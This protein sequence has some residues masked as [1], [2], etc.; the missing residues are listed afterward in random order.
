MSYAWFLV[1]ATVSSY[2]VQRAS[3]GEN[4]FV[5]AGSMHN[6]GSCYCKLESC[7][8]CMHCGRIVQPYV[9]V[10]ANT[11]KQS[12]AYPILAS[13]KDAVHQLQPLPQ[14]RHPC[15]QPICQTLSTTIHCLF[16]S[17]FQ[18]HVSVHICSWSITTPVSI[19]LLFP[20]YLEFI[21]DMYGWPGI[22]LLRSVIPQ[23]VKTADSRLTSVGT[24]WHEE[25]PKNL[26]SSWKNP[27]R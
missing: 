26:F 10:H 14:H 9:H 25:M 20:K 4:N 15:H 22:S 18:I 1:S 5:V 16:G 27:I 24:Q 13:G 19:V 8:G 12:E 7:T 2:Q 21:H 17:C 23:F 3:L 6:I 11:I